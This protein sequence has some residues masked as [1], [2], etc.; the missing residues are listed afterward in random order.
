LIIG[1]GWVYRAA[2]L[3][4]LAPGRAE[5]FDGYFLEPRI[6]L[7]EI[8][9]MAQHLSDND[10]ISFD[11]E[12]GFH[13]ELRSVQGL[14]ERRPPVSR[15]SALRSL[16]ALLYRAGRF[17]EAKSALEER[18]RLSSG[19]STPQDWAFLSLILH[20]LGRRGEA[21]QWLGRFRSR[22]ASDHP[23]AFWDELEIRLLRS[24]AE[25]VILHDPAFPA[26]PF[27]PP[28]R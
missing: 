18:I 16:G 26:D 3:A 13:L 19:E 20:R 9:R 11:Q 5:D 24:E 12:T 4:A 6:A 27:A 14:L 15:A 10:G 17:D 2:W 25:A 22:R 8:S 28:T 21:L 7:D 1:P 23:M